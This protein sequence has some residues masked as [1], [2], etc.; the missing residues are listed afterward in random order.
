[1]ARRILKALA[2][3]VF[4]LVVFMAVGKLLIQWSDRDHAKNA[5]QA[6]ATDGCITSTSALNVRPLGYSASEFRTYWRVLGTPRSGPPASTSPGCLVEGAAI[7]RTPAWVAEE[8]FLQFDLGFPLVY[9]GALLAALLLAWNALGRPF[10]RT[11]VIAPVLTLMVAD[12][13]ENSVHLWQISRWQAAGESALSSGAIA[14][15]SAATVLKIGFI[16]VCVLGL[17]GLLVWYVVRSPAA[18][19]PRVHASAALG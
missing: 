7:T 12:W 16:L 11:W 1:M 14:V 2:I 5:L 8:R 4:P 9:G 15:S 18:A 3:A 19:E 6:G 10:R 17:A 13:I